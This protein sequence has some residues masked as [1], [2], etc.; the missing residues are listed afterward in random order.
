MM[1]VFGLTA[2]IGQGLHNHLPLAVDIAIIACGGIVVVGAIVLYTAFT[3][4]GF[5]TGLAVIYNDQRARIDAVP[6]EQAPFVP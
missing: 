4:A 2:L 1:L 6:I 3:C 5:A